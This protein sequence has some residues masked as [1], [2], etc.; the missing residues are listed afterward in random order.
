MKRRAMTFIVII[1]VSI[2]CLGCDAIPGLG[3]EEPPPPQPVVQ[4][5]PPPMPQPGVQPAQPAQAVQPTPATIPG[6]PGVPPVAPGQPAAQ[7]GVPPAQPVTP[8]PP[9]GDALIDKVN[10]KK[11]QV[12]ANFIPT[13]AIVKQ[14]I[15][16]GSS[17]SYQ[18]QLPGPPFCHT[19]V[20]AADDKVANIDISVI[21]PTGAT[22]AQDSTTESVATVLNHCPA[23][24]GPYKLT[25]N[26]PKTTGQFAV[27]VYSK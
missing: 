13:S 18:V 17:Q 4:Q 23:V 1:G 16:K 5:L 14:T 12:A 21:S 11:F 6:Q 22:E 2:A 24:P 9:T 10:A 7:P 15:A 20:A 8:P 27:Q 19:Y 25:V 3:K 26:M